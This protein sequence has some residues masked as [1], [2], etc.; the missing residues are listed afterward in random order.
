MGSRTIRTNRTTLRG[1]EVRMEMQDK[2]VQHHMSQLMK[3][4]NP[5]V[6]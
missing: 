6:A 2:Q 3:T 1:L 4:V 5:K